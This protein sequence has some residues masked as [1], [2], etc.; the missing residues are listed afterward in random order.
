MSGIGICI[1]ICNSTVIMFRGILVHS[2][3]MELISIAHRCDSPCVT[4]FEHVYYFLSH[5]FC[6]L[7]IY[8]DVFFRYNTGPPSFIFTSVCVH[9]VFSVCSHT[10]STDNPSHIQVHAHRT[11]KPHERMYEI[12]GY[13]LLCCYGQITI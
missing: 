3:A 6:A 9:N 13:L 7:Q 2:V 1:C 4:H 8:F 5:S 11:H 12:F 10:H